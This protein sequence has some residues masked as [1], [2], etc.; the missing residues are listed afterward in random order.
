MS[1]KNPYPQVRPATDI[2]VLD[3]GV[4]IRA[5][6]PGVTEENLQLNQ[7]GNRLHIEASS[8]CPIPL[9]EKDVQTLEFGNVDFALDIIMQ[10]PLSAPLQTSLDKGVLSIFVP[11]GTARTD[12]P[13]ILR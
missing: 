4:E 5:N 3:N 2:I 11:C 6:M 9:E 12:I 8:H 7:V 13:I 10:H 1:R